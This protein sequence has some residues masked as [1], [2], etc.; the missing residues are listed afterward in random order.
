MEETITTDNT[1]WFKYIDFNG[2]NELCENSI[3]QLRV[4]KIFYPL[5]FWLELIF[6]VLLLAVSLF[7]LVNHHVA[8]V[9]IAFRDLTLV[10]LPIVPRYLVLRMILVNL[11]YQTGSKLFVSISNSALVLPANRLIGHKK[12]QLVLAKDDIKVQYM[13]NTTRHS[14][15]CR[16]LQLTIKSISKK[17]ITL[18]VDYFPIQSMLYLL[19]YFGYPLSFERTHFGILKMTRMFLLIIPVLCVIAI[20]GALFSDSFL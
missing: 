12:R 9:N 13:Q 16:A 4:T 15:S 7:P 8:I 5:P 1:H 20:S 19:T 2:K 18:K 10:Y 6:F 17:T 3:I 14:L 11:Y